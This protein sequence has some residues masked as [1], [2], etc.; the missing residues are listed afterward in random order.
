M[1]F[2]VIIDNGTRFRF[3]FAD[4]SYT[5]Q[6]GILPGTI[7]ADDKSIVEIVRHYED[8]GFEI[9]QTFSRV[10]SAGEVTPETE[11]VM[12]REKRITVCPR[13][14]YG[15]LKSFK[16]SVETFVV[17]HYSSD[18]RPIIKGNGFDGL[19]VGEDREQAEEFITFVNGLIEAEVNKDE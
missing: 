15:E 10:I 5:W 11:L 19:E 9:I 14:G 18:E 4:K 2:E 12:P 17:K 16:G 7:D 6:W 13:C 1:L 8:G 3:D